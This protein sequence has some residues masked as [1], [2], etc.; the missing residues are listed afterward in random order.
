MFKVAC[1]QTK[2]HV[3]KTRKIHRR[4]RKYTEDNNNNKNAYTLF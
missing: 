4:Q 2:M 3:W 1:K